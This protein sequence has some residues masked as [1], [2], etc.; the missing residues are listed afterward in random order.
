MESNTGKSN[1]SIIFLSICKDNT[2]KD[3]KI[4]SLLQADS[5]RQI[6]IKAN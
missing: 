1:S 6:N 4:N 5:H 2:E 3:R